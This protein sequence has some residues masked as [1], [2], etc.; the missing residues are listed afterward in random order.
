MTIKLNNKKKRWK[1]NLKEKK[2]TSQVSNKEK[3]TIWKEMINKNMNV[4][5]KK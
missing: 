3:L 4:K 5:F 2:A 1:E